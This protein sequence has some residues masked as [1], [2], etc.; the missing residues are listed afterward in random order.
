MSSRLLPLMWFI[1]IVL[2]LDDVRHQ[3]LDD[4]SVSTGIEHTCALHIL[5]EGDFA[6]RV[7]CWGSNGQEQ[8]L[9]PKVYEKTYMRGFV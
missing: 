7:L 8:S 4:T 6:G 1:R 5:K 3:I 2:C 9:S